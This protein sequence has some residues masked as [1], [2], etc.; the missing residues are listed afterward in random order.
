VSFFSHNFTMKVLDLQCSQSHQFEGWFG[1]EDDF[2]TQLSR[3]LVECPMC[4]Q[5]DISKRLSAPR[6]NL[7][8]SKTSR[9][10]GLSLAQPKVTSAEAEEKSSNNVAAGS[11]AS[12][13]TVPS[14]EVAL[15]LDAHTQ[16]VQQQIQANWLKMVQLVIA[17]TDD[18]GTQFADEA[19]KMHYGETQ[20]RNIRGQVSAEESLELIEEGIPVM[21]LMIPSALKGPV[22]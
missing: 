20:E 14:N 4:G 21:P 17:N 12:S 9:T 22:Q 1:S 7:L 5:V 13:E 15:A 3:G 6:L 19:R 8:S 10:E 18:V 2:Q 16:D 11:A